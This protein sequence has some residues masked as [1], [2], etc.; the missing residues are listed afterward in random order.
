[1]APGL[2]EE[3]TTLWKKL[4]INGLKVLLIH[5]TARTLLELTKE[6]E[7]LVP[8]QTQ[9]CKLSPHQAEPGQSSN[10]TRC[11]RTYVFEAPVEHLQ[12]FFGELCLLLQL[13]HAFRPV[14]NSGELEV[15]FLAVCVTKRRRLAF[16]VATSAPLPGQPPE[17][18]WN[19]LQS[20]AASFTDKIK[21]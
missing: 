19:S 12:L 7:L 8:I 13:V 18:T 11:R 17:T 5:H 15:I 4:G 1:M 20:N 6:F 21:T 2:G 9:L 14:T 3:L 16:T 10:W